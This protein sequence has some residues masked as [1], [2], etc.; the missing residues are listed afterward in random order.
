MI[1]LKAIGAFFVK[2][3]RWIKETAWVQPLLIVGAIFAIIF[4]IPHITDWVNSWGFG[5]TGAFFSSQKQTLEGEKTSRTLGQKDDVITVADT[6]TNDI[7]ANTQYAYNSEFDKINTEKYGKKF[8][9]IYTANDCDACN[10]AENAFKYLSDKW[11]NTYV[12]TDNGE[13]K[14]YT[15]FTDETSSNDGDYTNTGIDTKAFY[16]YLDRHSD[17]FN[18]TSSVLQEAPYKTNASIEDKNY[19]YYEQPDTTNFVTPTI[20]LV[21]YSKEAQDEK[22]A[23]VSE[24]L[25][26]IT[27]T[28]ETEKADVLL[29]MWNHI[30]KD[31]QNI[32][33]KVY[34]KI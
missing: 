12:P 5:S 9:L 28:T 6:I 8:F 26:G 32:F 20:L 27:G 3:W 29:N 10:K 7:Y 17:F 31:T 1:I 19:K 25:F 13:L 15:L 22:R 24:V 18:I 33:S 16:R 21:D 4:S 23:G 11:G 34:N 2:I 30:D 14:F